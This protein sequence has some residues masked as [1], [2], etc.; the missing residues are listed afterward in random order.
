MGEPRPDDDYGGSI[1]EQLLDLHTWIRLCPPAFV[2]ED[3][4]LQPGYQLPIGDASFIN[5]DGS[6]VADDVATIVHRVANSLEQTAHR[7]YLSIA[8]I[9]V[10]VLLK[11]A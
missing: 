8:L 1:G 10:V 11:S 9:V 3:A 4:V 2:P 6:M 5:T 7:L